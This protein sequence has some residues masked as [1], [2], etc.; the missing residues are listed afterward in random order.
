[1]SEDIA[2]MKRIKVYTDGSCI[3]HTGIGG[4]AVAS[5][6][7]TQCGMKRHTTNNEMELTAVYYAALLSSDYDEVHI[8]TDSQYAFK[9]FTEWACRWEMNGWKKKGSGPI[10]NLDLIK[11]IYGITKDNPGIFFHKVKAHSG[12]EW[13]ER[14]DKLAKKMAYQEF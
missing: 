8:Y 3:N 5:Y 1:M 4:W 7:I 12:D 6:Q 14:A 13:N 9:A 11:K 10:R 2:D